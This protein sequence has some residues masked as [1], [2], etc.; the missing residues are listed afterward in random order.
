M[1]KPKLDSLFNFP[2]CYH[3]TTILSV[4]DDEAF[5]NILSSR[6]A[7]EIPVLCFSEPKDALEYTKNHHAHSPFRERCLKDSSSE[8][9]KLDLDAIRNEIYNRDRFKE[10]Y[11]NV[12]DYDMP[13]INGIEL[14][15][16]MEFKPDIPRYS[17]IF[18]T[19][20]ISDDFMKKVKDK[21]Y[22]GKD[23]PNVINTLLSKIE[24]R[25]L[26][27]FQ[28][29]SHE[30]ARILSRNPNE[31]TAILFDGNFSQVFNKYLNENK[32]CEFY[33]FDKQGSYIL[34]DDDANIS[35]LFIRNEKGM[36]NSIELAKEFGAPKEIIESLESKK[37]LLSLYERKDFESRENI[38]WEGHLLPANE[39]ISNDEYL[40]F[41]SDLKPKEE[42]KYY[43]AF[44]KNFPGNHIDNS[45]IISYNSYLSKQEDTN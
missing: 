41:F 18:L 13:H 7:D 20:K 36:K 26:A 29:Y 23:D 39:F 15:K 17:H 22:I 5:L 1:I 35:Y 16:T 33:L 44:T 8:Q 37:F 24:K 25:G 9:D 14:T 40:R 31:K 34:L 30:I 42:P 43:Y 10:I 19:G 32:I 3:P 21:D 28:M 45:R 4:D 27:I 12:T 38:D 2:V 11:I 6:L